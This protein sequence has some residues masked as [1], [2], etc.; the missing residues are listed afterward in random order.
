[1][2]TTFNDKYWCKSCN[3]YSQLNMYT[4]TPAG[5]ITQPGY[6][7]AVHVYIAIIL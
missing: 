6:Y 3:M 2:D 4:T 7:T 1:M 5:S